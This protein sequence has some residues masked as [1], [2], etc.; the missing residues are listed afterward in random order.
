MLWLIFWIAIAAVALFAAKEI[1]G[2]GRFVR[3]DGPATPPPPPIEPS[4][5][6]PAEPGAPV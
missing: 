4:S 1:E 5:L 6:P 2:K 3:P